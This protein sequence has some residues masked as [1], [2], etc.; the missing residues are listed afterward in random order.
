[1]TSC[2]RQPTN[3]KTTKIMQKYFDKYAKEYP[4]SIIGQYKVE[5]IN[6]LHIEEVHKDKV[7]AYAILILSNGVGIQTRFT[8]QKK[9]PLG[10]RALAWENMG[11]AMKRP[12][13]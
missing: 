7:A 2:G 9:L 12:N 13:E 11:M 5:D 8:I 4:E 6:L 3:K 10:W 1:M